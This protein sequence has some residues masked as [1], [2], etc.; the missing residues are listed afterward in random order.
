M[1]HKFEAVW[2]LFTRLLDF[3][4]NLVSMQIK[5]AK[6]KCD[7]FALDKLSIEELLSEL[8]EYPVFSVAIGIVY[9]SILSIDEL[10]TPTLSST[11]EMQRFKSND[12]Y[13]D[14]Y[15][16]S[17]QD[18]AQLYRN[19]TRQEDADELDEILQIFKHV[20]NKDTRHETIQWLITEYLTY[21]LVGDV[22]FEE[23]F[24]D[25][26]ESLTKTRDDANQKV[27]SRRVNVYSSYF[28]GFDISKEDIYRSMQIKLFHLYA[29]YASNRG[30]GNANPNTHIEPIVEALQGKTIKISPS[31]IKNIYIKGFCFGLAVFDYKKNMEQKNAIDEYFMLQQQ[32][33][34]AELFPFSEELILKQRQQLLSQLIL[35]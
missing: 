3:E 9:E 27:L 13:L 11:K 6:K 16:N 35:L 19:I 30:R 29:N 7:F 12:K 32:G 2:K 20:K 5:Y 8:S 31:K 1:N 23:L 24:P 21:F 14:R 22:S 28:D 18:T 4:P 26:P 17:F 15:I 10:L 34:L 33:V 25:L